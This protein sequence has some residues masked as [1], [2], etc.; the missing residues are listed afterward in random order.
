MAI[1]EDFSQISRIMRHISAYLTR[2]ERDYSLLVSVHAED[3]FFESFLLDLGWHNHHI[4]P[5]CLYVKKDPA[6]AHRCIHN[7]RM[8]AAAFSADPTPRFGRC[9]FGVEEFDLPIKSEGTAVGFI[10][11]T[12]YCTDPEAARAKAVHRGM[13]L[14]AAYEKALASLSPVLPD[15][16]LLIELFSPIADLLGFVYIKTRQRKKRTVLNYNSLVRYID[17]HYAEPISVDVLAAA[18]YCSPSLINH[19]FKKT[20]GLSVSAY[21]TKVR[22]EHA[23][24]LLAATDLPVREVAFRVGFDDSNYFSSVFTKQTGETPRRF[25]AGR[26][27]YN[28]ENDNE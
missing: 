6:F 10:S 19:L 1:N 21:V 25:R 14:D 22:I 2:I 9:A 28:A 3:H 18:S 5:Y 24:T 23:R 13:T 8:V 17:R 11:V 26:G 4:C 7:Q 27:R 20:G 16:K 15:P 12:G